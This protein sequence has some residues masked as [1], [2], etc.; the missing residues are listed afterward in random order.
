MSYKINYTVYYE[1]TTDYVEVVVNCDCLHSC[2]E[3]KFGQY[4]EDDG[5]I[6]VVYKDNIIYAKIGVSC[7]RE[8]Y[9]AYGSHCNEYNCYDLYMANIL[10]NG[11]E[12][13]DK[14]IFDY[15]YG[16]EMPSHLKDPFIFYENATIEISSSNK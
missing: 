16:M 6:R 12:V 2:N 10:V 14:S 4:M 5:S 1:K 13:L 7:M 3:N 8:V 15:M 9:E 11:E